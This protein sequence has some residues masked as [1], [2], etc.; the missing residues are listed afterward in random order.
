[1]YVH[2]C[3]CLRVFLCLDA[4][5]LAAFRVRVCVCVCVSARLHVFLCLDA[6]SLAALQ[7]LTVCVAGPFF[8]PTMLEGCAQHSKTISTRHHHSNTI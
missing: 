4:G 3:L 7:L 1:M 6:P 2:V 8:G 5:L